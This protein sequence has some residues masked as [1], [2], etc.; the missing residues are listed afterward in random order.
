MSRRHCSPNRPH[1]HID[2]TLLQRFGQSIHD[3]RGTARK[4][5]VTVDDQYDRALAMDSTSGSIS[6][7][8]S[9]IFFRGGRVVSWQGVRVSNGILTRSLAG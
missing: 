1:R 9:A 2:G 8:N 5:V 3:I 6:E 7:T 4:Y